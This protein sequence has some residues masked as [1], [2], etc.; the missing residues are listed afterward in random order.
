MMA[1]SSSAAYGG[2]A[3]KLEDSPEP[4]PPRITP[5]NDPHCEPAINWTPPALVTDQKDPE[6]FLRRCS[7]YIKKTKARCSA[8][9]GR[10]SHHAK[11]SHPKFLPTCYAHRDQRS[12]AGWCQFQQ[13]DG[14]RC[15]RL[16]RWTPP[17]LELCSEHQCRPD[18]P[19]Y[20]MKLPLELRL[21]IFRYLLPSEPIGSSSSPMHQEQNDTYSSPSLPPIASITMNNWGN[22]LPPPPPTPSRPPPYV[23]P[24]R[25]PCR[26]FSQSPAMPPKT[27]PF[28]IVDLFL[29]NRQVHVE[30]KDLLYSTVPFVIDIRKDGTFM[31]GRR[32]LEPRRADGLPH[33]AVDDAEAIAQRFI[34]SFDWTSVKNYNVDILVENW[35]AAT[36]PGLNRPDSSWDEEVE[37]YDI[38]D[39]VG[40]AVT[41]ILSKARNLCRLNVRLG[42]SKFRWSDEELL[43]N[44]KCLVAPFNRLRNVR[45]PRFRGVFDGTTR[46][47]YMINIASPA[48]QLG[49]SAGPAGLGLA[50]PKPSLCSVPQFPMRTLLLGPGNIEFDQF[51][52]GWESCLSQTADGPPKKAPIRNMFI[53][54]KKFYC[55]L[56]TVVPEVMQ[57][58]GRRAFLHRARVA[59]E[60][61]DLEAFREVRNELIIYW[62]TY[63]EQEEAKK[64]DMNA[65]LSR[66]LD[67]D[68]YSSTG[69]EQPQRRGSS[70]ASPILLDVEKMTA[71]GIP[72][73]GN[74]MSDRQ[75]QQ[76]QAMVT[77]QRQ[78]Q[79]LIMARQQTQ[80]TTHPHGIHHHM[81]GHASRPPNLH[82]NPQSTIQ[83]QAAHVQAQRNA[84]ISATAT[85][86]RAAQLAAEQQRQQQRQFAFQQAQPAFRATVSHP[87]NI[88]MPSMPTQGSDFINVYGPSKISD[89]TFSSTSHISVLAS[90]PSPSASTASSATLPSPHE[91]NRQGFSIPPEC[92][93]SSSG[94]TPATVTTTAQLPSPLTYPDTTTSDFSRS[95][96][97]KHP[98]QNLPN[99]YTSYKRNQ[100]QNQYQV[101]NEPTVQ[102]FCWLDPPCFPLHTPQQQQSQHPI[103]PNYPNANTVS[104]APDDLPPAGAPD[105]N[106]VCFGDHNAR[107]QACYGKDLN[108]PPPGVPDPVS[109]LTPARKKRRIDNTRD[110]N[111]H[112]SREVGGHPDG[113][114]G[115]KV[116]LLENENSG[117]QSDE[118]KWPDHGGPSNG[119]LAI[120]EWDFKGKGKQR[121]DVVIL[122]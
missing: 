101:Q 61:E 121:V 6:G 73:Q 2:P 122:D 67:A 57:R 47:P 120:S 28:P 116:S 91:S 114:T 59:R 99:V 20:F 27:F 22:P 64:D 45:Q 88:A 1:A 52:E 87:Q 80:A 86:R 3:I 63:L 66:M 39:Y 43:S 21:E 14:A 89:S 30:A 44:T 23:R 51:R 82:L 31:C 8:A 19:C 40:A 107:E 69:S 96:Q 106:L 36:P 74:Q 54:F 17:Y 16:F 98:N 117:M 84:V 72:M 113:D 78:L 71:E 25:R 81:T 85:R 76:R 50:P 34:R 9:I 77:R 79:G 46:T 62:Y 55:E 102:T 108:C 15:G 109:P 97:N 104:L 7:G 75:I 118:L 53:E 115:G 38:R 92:S 65:R 4:S 42:L 49:P 100:T 12:F 56:S 60:N 93:S 11:N 5:S 58:T 90:S 18:T 119:T 105:S 103:A 29:V 26:V 112:G 70:A 24:W 41:G 111:G 83:I 37:I 10:N 110:E 35:N 95:C 13:Q 94:S 68:T 32:L 48:I 33:C